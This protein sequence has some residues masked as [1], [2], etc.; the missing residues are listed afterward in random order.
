M[1]G[2]NGA[3]L[4]VASLKNGLQKAKKGDLRISL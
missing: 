4:S 2:S 3:S 1:R